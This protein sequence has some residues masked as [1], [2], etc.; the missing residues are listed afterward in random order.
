[1]SGQNGK[2]HIDLAEH[3]FEGQWIDL[4]DIGGKSPKQ[5]RKVQELAVDDSQAGARAFIAYVVS[6]W[7]ITDPE[8]GAS[9]PPPSDPGLDLE[10]LPIRVTKVLNDAVTAQL[11]DVLPKGSLT[12]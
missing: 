8:T 6:A 4:V 7:N 12:R 9:I 1:M 5:F 11:E 10:A 3:G 2:S